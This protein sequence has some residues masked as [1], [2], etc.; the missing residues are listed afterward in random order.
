MSVRSRVLQTRIFGSLRNKLLVWFLL[1]SLMPLVLMGIINYAGAREN[2]K[3]LAFDQLTA[4]RLA[5]TIQIEN[6]FS[7][8]R[9]DMGALIDAVMTTREDTFSQLDVVRSIKQTQIQEYFE[10]RHQELAGLVELLNLLPQDASDSVTPSTRSILQSYPTTS[11]IVNIYLIRPDGSVYFSLVPEL[12]RQTNLLTGT[13]RNTNLGKLVATVLATKQ[14]ALSDF[15]RYAPHQYQPAAFL[16]QPLLRNN[17]M[18]AIVALQ[19]SYDGINHIM[20]DGTGLGETGESYLIGALPSSPSRPLSQF[21]FRSNSRLRDPISILNSAYPVNTVAAE[22]I[23]AGKTGHGVITNYRGAPVLSSWVPLKIAGLDWGIVTE[24]GV[25]EG[26]TPRNSASSKDFFVRNKESYGAQDLFLISPGGGYIFYSVEHKSDY[27]KSLF[28]GP[29]QNTNLARLI[30]QVLQTKQFGMVDFERYEPSQFAP[31]AF[32][33]QPLLNAQGNIDIIVAAQLSLDQITAI[34]QERTGLGNTGETYLVGP[35]LLWRSNSRSAE[36]MGV[37]TT[38]LNPDTAVNTIATRSAL[39]GDRG[40][41]IIDNYRQI[42]VLSSWSPITLNASETNSETIHWAL[43]AEIDESEVNQ[44]AM[45]T[46]TTIGL[47]LFIAILIVTLATLFVSRSLSAPIVKVAKAATNIANGDL[48][49]RVTLDTGDEIQQMANAF[50]H[51]ADEIG[52]TVLALKK[53]IAEHEQAR[54]ELN[55]HNQEL[56]TLNKFSAELNQ[57]VNPIQALENSIDRAWDLLSLK[58]VWLFLTDSKGSLELATARGLPPTLEQNLVDRKKL[59][60]CQQQM[61]N[62]EHNSGI[63]LIHCE[64]LASFAEY[65]LTTHASVPLHV[66]KAQI[67][68]LN[69]ARTNSTPFSEDHFPLLIA[70]SNQLSVAIERARLFDQ[71]QRLALTDPLT[72][73]YNRRHFFELAEKE[74]DRALRYGHPLS[75][76]LFDIDHF[77]QVN[78][79]WGHAV[80]DQVLCHLVDLSREGLRQTDILGRYGGEEF[81]ALLPETSLANAQPIAERIR[82]NIA[83]AALATLKGTV[84]FTVSVG[85]AAMNSHD[86][87]FDKV[88]ER[89]DQAM[90]ASKQRGRNRVTLWQSEIDRFSHEVK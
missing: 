73:L 83:D 39:T 68:I 14:F 36:Q 34:M 25:E 18:V 50:N 4:L 30:N 58:A 54:S 1:L 52:E 56:E 48:T 22:N 88:L 23:L 51:M 9:R 57:T 53:A 62:D 38:I 76:V 46:T 15:E 84:K 55:L 65:E 47:V 32:I 6:Y 71:V 3:K 66:G 5:K 82:T 20:Q 16:A 60:A 27:R 81:I 61:V 74:L 49:Q 63:C 13:F 41:A 11:D 10:S 77:K 80:G 45:Q 89:A 64:W 85:V 35:D 72:G 33:A 69:L 26:F 79:L 67:G 31:A 37:A 2:F 86:S 70:M 28:S 21:Y 12:D 87:A 43:I 42:R 78:D 29:Y 19:L 90:Y 8:Q 44:P 7:E 40:T 59:C 75:V 24:V 17:E